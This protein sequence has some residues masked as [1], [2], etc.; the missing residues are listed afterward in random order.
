[1]VGARLWYPNNTLQHGGVILG[2][3]GVAGHSHK[4]L[5]RGDAGYFGRVGLIQNFSAVT[6]ACMLM[7]KANFLLAGGLD[8]E[9][10]S[11]AFNDVDLCLKMNQH[12]LRVVWT[13]YAELYHHESASRGYEDTPEK[14]ARFEKERQVMKDRW[15]NFILMDP[16]YSPN[17]TLETQDFAYAWPP[18][19]SS[20]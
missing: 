11:T 16:A 10:L 20:L 18:R 6:G 2:I 9:H 15:P 13:P 19:V 5:P 1:V 7:R 12:N 8:A 4:G 3:G 14:L 17:L